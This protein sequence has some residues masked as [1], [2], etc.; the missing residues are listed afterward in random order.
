M[1]KRFA[2]AR[3]DAL[4]LLAVAVLGGLLVLPGLLRA[5][6]VAA[7]H[8]RANNYRELAAA[9]MTYHDNHGV[10]PYGYSYNFD[11]EDEAKRVALKYCEKPDCQVITIVGNGCTALAVGDGNGYGYGFAR[12]RAGAENRAMEEC[13]KR[14]TGCRAICWTCTD[15]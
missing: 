4:V 13:K 7:E 6:Q 11:T 3:A 12:D 2:L 5:R 9:A 14:T 8:E 15:R 10:F 1:R